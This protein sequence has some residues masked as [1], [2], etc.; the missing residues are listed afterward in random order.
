MTNIKEVYDELMALTF[1]IHFK[2][3]SLTGIKKTIF[4][5]ITKKLYY[6]KIERILENI[7]KANPPITSD[8][9]YDI[10]SRIQALDN[11]SFSNCK[12]SF[13]FIDSFS[14]VGEGYFIFN[15]AIPF[16]E[17]EPT[18]IRVVVKT[19]ELNI[20]FRLMDDYSNS[21]K[22]Y[23]LVEKSLDIKKDYNPINDLI[24][25]LNRNMLIIYKNYMLID[26]Q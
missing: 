4:Q 20:K 14:N 24:K 8:I 21:Y 9:F 26:L 12:Y 18:S 22:H 6:K 17:E 23:E 19:D 13:K 10:I 11:E 7:I 15:I 5:K 3:N 25:E 1:D 16:E 2:E